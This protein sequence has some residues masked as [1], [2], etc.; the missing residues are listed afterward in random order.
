MYG[1]VR[2]LLTPILWEN[3]IG[4]KDMTK[5]QASQSFI[6]MIITKINIKTVVIII[7]IVAGVGI[8]RYLIVGSPIIPVKYMHCDG[9][10][11][12][13]YYGFIVGSYRKDQVD[14]Y[15][16]EGKR[17]WVSSIPIVKGFP[18]VPV[19]GLASIDYYQYHHSEEGEYDQENRRCINGRILRL[20]PHSTYIGVLEFP[21]DIAHLSIY[22]QHQMQWQLTITSLHHR[23][24]YDKSID[25]MIN[26]T[27]QVLIYR[28]IDDN[29]Q[30]L[31]AFVNR[32]I[33]QTTHLNSEKESMVAAYLQ[34]IPKPKVLPPVD[35]RDQQSVGS[36]PYRKY[37][38][39]QTSS[40]LNIQGYGFNEHASLTT[41]TSTVY[42]S[43]MSRVNDSDELYAD[44]VF[45][46]NNV[47]YFEL[48]NHIT[49]G[50]GGTVILSPDYHHIL[51][52]DQASHWGLLKY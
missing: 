26:D 3:N 10:E 43:Y 12:Y 32:G 35:W 11:D 6:K 41:E 27:G 25:L 52:F 50:C 40:G 20:S 29:N 48:G 18:D 21:A 2:R 37:I 16:W 15:N 49:G 36:A 33:I 8:L 44:I 28:I 13:N 4:N 17:L 42:G 5:H 7:T 51:L 24:Y 47:L 19:Q 38:L 45:P 30:Q 23:F 22:K 46:D 9:I 14:Y 31:L 39:V 34:T 1:G